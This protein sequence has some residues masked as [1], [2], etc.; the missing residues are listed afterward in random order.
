MAGMRFVLHRNGLGRYGIVDGHWLHNRFS[1]RHGERG[2]SI[3]RILLALRRRRRPRLGVPGRVPH[4]C[5]RHRHRHTQTTPSLRHGAEPL[6]L[7]LLTV[8]SSARPTCSQSA[9]RGHGSCMNGHIIPNDLPTRNKTAL[10][11]Q[12]HRVRHTTE[13]G[14]SPGRRLS[15]SKT[16]RSKT[17]SSAKLSR[18]DFQGA[19]LGLLPSP[20]RRCVTSNT[21]A[22]P[23]KALLPDEAIPRKW[24]SN[25]LPTTLPTIPNA[26]SATSRTRLLLR[27]LRNSKL[28]I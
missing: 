3:A 16:V 22:R 14:H 28:V 21:R 9:P 12:R 5:H 17:G 6:L 11:N 23:L 13:Q 27:L 7:A 8:P 1:C 25:G 18:F 20:R 10:S 2:P 24:T 4:H 15:L 26:S 19:R